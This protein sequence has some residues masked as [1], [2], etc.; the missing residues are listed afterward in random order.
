M[1]SRADTVVPSPASRTLDLKA[2][3]EKP[4]GV[5]LT[6]QNTI[7]VAEIN[8]K[9]VSAQSQPQLATASTL[10][11]LALLLMFTFAQFLDAFN[12]SALLPA[13]PQISSKLDFV[14]TETVWIISAY[15]LTFAAFLLVSGRI[16]DVFTPKPAFITGCLVLG[17]THLIGGFAHQK[18][19]ILVLRALGGIGGALTIPSA[20]SLIV[21]LFPD[22]EP[23]A[24]AIS[25]FGSAGAIGNISGILIGAVLV[26]YAG[27]PWIFWFVAIVGVGIAIICFFL[28]P[29]ANN[30]ARKKVNF[31]AI[32]VSILTS[33]VILF[34]FAVTSGSTQGW[35]TAY[36]LAPLAISLVLL[37]I[38]FLWE[39]RIPPDDAV[40][41][42]RIWSYSNF[43][44][45]A[46]L[47]LL[48]FFWWVTSF[49]LLTQWWQDVYGWTA[50]STAV[51]FL[52]FG[53]G[54]WLISFVIGKLPNY[55]SYKQIL[56]TGLTLAGVATTLLPFADVPTTYWRF[57][58]PAFLIG[59]VGMQIV[60]S[61]ASIAI[62]AYTPPNVAGTVG[63]V[64]NCA[65][66][67]GSAVGLAAV[68]SISTSIDQRAH[69]D[70]PLEEWRTRMVEITNAMW[71]RA[72]AGK[73]ASYWFLL[74]IIA[75]QFV[76][77]LI[78]FKTVPSRKT[79]EIKRVDIESA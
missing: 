54:A 14:L 29:K 40:L 76:S 71:K 10:R 63:A 49:V 28:I 18:I 13:I 65:L 64:F 52:P 50:I 68:S 21:Q 3:T 37:A 53:I 59:T 39:S 26:Q 45:L 25:L 4:D 15:Q 2:S 33:A 7:E 61:T 8:E 27:W 47:S 31:D 42:P 73:A 74:G 67:L 57:A 17:I 5:A 38:F 51:H 66:Q 78:F 34:I 20:L 77:V 43:T 30:D 44:V 12:N 1:D 16:A 23:Q 48:P 58:F 46:T 62:F 32:G 22:P 79:E 55:F 72:Y 69:F 60:F 19:A 11:K 6:A 70:I 35:P 9:S 41:P 56:L 75:I 24:R 36:V